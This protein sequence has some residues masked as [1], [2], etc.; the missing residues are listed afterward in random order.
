MFIYTKKKCQTILHSTY[1]RFE[2]KKGSLSESVKQEIKNGILILQAAIH[3]SDRPKMVESAKTL[4]RLRKEHLSKTSIELLLEYSVGIAVALL[5]A[6][7]VRPMVFEL[8]VVPTG[9]MRPTIL[10]QDRLFVSKTSYGINIPLVPN[11]FYFD[12]DLVDRCDGVAF[13]GENLDIPNVDVMNFYVLPGK[14][15]LVKRLLGKPGD[16]LYFYG[17][18]IYGFDIDGKDISAE[19]QPEYLN[20]VTHVPFITFEGKVRTAGSHTQGLSSPVVFVQYGMPVAELDAITSSMVHGRMLPQKG[21]DGSERHF[22]HYYE[23]WG[24]ANYGMVRL[25]TPAQM[26]QFSRT[27]HLDSDAKAYLE[28][29]HHPNLYSATVNRDLKG[30]IRPQIGSFTSYLA[31]TDIHLQKLFS[32]MTTMRFIVKDGRFFQYSYEG[33]KKEYHRYSPSFKGIPDGTYEYAN[34]TAYEISSLG[35]RSEV[36]HEHPLTKY[37]AEK[38]LFFFN[39]G[40]EM[41][42]PFLPSSPEDLLRPSRYTF[43]K[44]GNLYLMGQEI[45]GKNDPQMVDF[46]QSEYAK[47]AAGTSSRPYLPFEDEGPP[48]LTNGKLDREKIMKQGLVIPKDHYLALGDNYEASLDSRDFGFLPRTNIRG[49]PTFI[50]WPISSRFGGFPGPSMHFFNLPR[51]LMWG[52]VVIAMIIYSYISRKKLN[53]PIVFE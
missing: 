14:K 18:Q 34:G 41:F 11:Q 24:I 42:S 8:Y 44:D 53:K 16:T 45:V 40:I 43:F 51:L 52:I 26:K 15:Q 48:L 7:L 9:S 27:S 39:L 32:H 10:E 3:D 49:A 35:N 21:A 46:L 20:Y 36:R 23:M 28:I 5:I 6:V 38:T 1:A 50:F 25:L 2:K 37:S 29:D 13:T 47:Q 19:L 17:G 4:Q 33:I 31:L 12:K 30:R 22:D